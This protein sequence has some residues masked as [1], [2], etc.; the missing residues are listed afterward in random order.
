MNPGRPVSLQLVYPNGVQHIVCS[1][2]W[3]FSCRSSSL[4]A[5]ATSTK[6]AYVCEIKSMLINFQFGK[7]RGGK[8]TP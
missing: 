7:E 2:G 4:S 5:N 6:Q 8:I 3:N 1:S